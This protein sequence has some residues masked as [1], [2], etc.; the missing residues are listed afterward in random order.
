MS[1]RTAVL[2][3]LAV[4]VLAYVILLWALPALTSNLASCRAVG[5][6]AAF[7]MPAAMYFVPGVVGILL[8]VLIMKHG[9]VVSKDEQSR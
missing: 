7:T 2:I 9:K 5:V 3:T 1:K 4:I 6:E 8:I